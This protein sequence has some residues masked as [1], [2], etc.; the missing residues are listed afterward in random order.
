MTEQTETT[1]VL[2]VYGRP[3]IIK[4]TQSLQQL[5]NLVGGGYIEYVFCP[6]NINEMFLCEPKWKLI[7]E[8][9]NKKERLELNIIVSENSIGF[10]PNTA[11]IIFKGGGGCPH[12]FGNVILQ[13]NT[14][15]WNKIENHNILLTE[16]DE[17]A[18][19]S[20]EIE[21]S[22]SSCSDDSD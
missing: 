15:E 18:I 22:Y 3:F 19:D 8:L 11:T 1:I 6:V 2:P 12:L 13:M 10:A 20:E 21:Y 14:I 5:R 9:L 4:E 7:Q 16:I 17:N